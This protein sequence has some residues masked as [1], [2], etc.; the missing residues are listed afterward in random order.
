MRNRQSKF[1]SFLDVWIENRIFLFLLIAIN[2]AGTLFGFYY[3]GIQF[4]EVQASLWPFVPD[5]PIATLAFALALSYFAIKKKFNSLLSTFA[6]FALVKV[7]IWTLFAMIIYSP[8]FFGSGNAFYYSI[9]FIL[10]AGMVA[11]AFVLLRRAS[12]QKVFLA[13]VAGWFLLNDFS[14]YF[15]GTVPT[16]IGTFGHPSLQTIL[17]IESFLMTLV[18]A[19]ILKNKTTFYPSLRS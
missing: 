13:L 7:G 8:Y 2:I 18:L 5:S 16:P 3:Y 12:I 17:A 10:H 19:I 15:L 9:L 1:A 6:I 14:D 11:E 4:S